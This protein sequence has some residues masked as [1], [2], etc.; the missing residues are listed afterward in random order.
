MDNFKYSMLVVDEAHYIKNPEAQRTQNVIKLSEH[1]QRLLFMT[2]TALE[3]KVDE[4]ISLIKILKP[5]IASAVHGME[6]MSSAP[7][8]REKVAP[9]YYR[10]KREDVLTELPDL[11]ESREWCSMTPVE[12]AIYEESIL[13]KHFMEAR[14]VSWNVPNLKDSSKARRRIC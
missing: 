12:E 8:F 6:F 7:Q 13:G 5:D 3:N 10:R 9:V 14:R 4:M 2:G 1:A 11:I